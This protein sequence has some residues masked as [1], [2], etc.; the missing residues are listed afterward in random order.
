LN[1][2]NNRQIQPITSWF[3]NSGDVTI[4]TLSL[5]DFYHYHFDNGG[6]KVSYS[7]SGTDLVTQS[8][9]N[10]YSDTMDVPSSV[11]QQWG[12]DDDVIWDYVAQTLGLT[13]L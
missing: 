4:D 6:G 12:A 1:N 2:M 11:I 10:Y 8:P 7:L 5:T 3:P 9:I 13:L